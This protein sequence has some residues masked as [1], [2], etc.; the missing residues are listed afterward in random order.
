MKFISW[1]Q[2]PGLVRRRLA[3][4]ATSAVMAVSITFG[5][6][7]MTMAHAADAPTPT[8]II[9]GVGANESQRVVSWY[10]SAATA[11]VVQVAPT[12]KLVKGEFPAD[13]VTFPATTAAN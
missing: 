12:A 1:T 8:G 6:G 13:A 10:S 4:G 7:L 3:V 9:L 11:Q 2:A 5:G